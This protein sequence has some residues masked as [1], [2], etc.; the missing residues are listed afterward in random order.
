MQTALCH[1][2]TLNLPHEAK[3]LI[4]AWWHHYWKIWIV[5]ARRLVDPSSLTSLNYFQWMTCQHGQDTLMLSA[6]IQT[7]PFK[8][9]MMLGLRTILTCNFLVHLKCAYS[10]GRK[11]SIGF[12]I[13]LRNSDVWFIETENYVFIRGLLHGLPHEDNKILL[14]QGDF[15]L[16]HAFFILFHVMTSNYCCFWDQ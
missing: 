8:A 4:E 2:V 3:V 6:V 1:L 16:L 13:E 14:H 9:H 11:S 15:L 10:F 12:A 7:R 5:I